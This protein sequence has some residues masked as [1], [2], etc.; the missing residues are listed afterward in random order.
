MFVNTVYQ[1]RR[2]KLKHRVDTGVIWLQGNQEVGMNYPGNPFPYRQ[3]SNMLYYT[4]VEKPNTHLI[5]DVDEDQEYLVGDDLTVDE[6]IWIGDQP[7][8]DFHADAAGITRT[9]PTSELPQ[10]LKQAV[11]SGRTVHTLP[12]YHGYQKD[13]ILQ[14]TG[15]AQEPSEDLI[16]AIVD[17]RSVKEDREIIEIENA[18]GTT[19]RIHQVV[20]E[21]T[22]AGRSEQ[23]IYAK[24]MEVVYRDGGR[25][26][27]NPILTIKGQI[28]HINT[29]QNYLKEDQML[30]CDMGAENAMH[31]A[32][33]ITRTFPVNRKF[34]A[35]QRSIYEIVLSTLQRATERVRPGIQ[36]KDIHRYAAKDIAQGLIDLG[37]MKG[38]ADDI[39]AEGA[40]ALFFPHGLGHMIG[41]DVHDMEGLGETYV[42]Y[43]SVTK[44][45]EQFGTA[46]LRLG[47]ILEENFVITVEPG[48]YFIPNLIQIWKQEQKFQ[49]FINYDKLE[50]WMDFGGVR[51]EDDVLVTKA[52]SEILG[53]LIPKTIEE[54]ESV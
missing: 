17:Q 5:I 46:N 12:T 19:A 16:R 39:V 18:L 6:T 25:L 26:A 24:A 14:F 21:E 44:R 31:Y 54:I 8:M 3:D 53:P 23:E 51:I 27:Y 33:D 49:D 11:L 34:N 2:R 48:L 4:G 41:L 38:N 52:G 20:L 1:N 22:F 10:I 50:P 47:R 43:N 7:G 28:L 45:S 13:K 29:Y 32:S 15:A 40:H 36:F 9:L 42:G 30:I 35:R 37:L